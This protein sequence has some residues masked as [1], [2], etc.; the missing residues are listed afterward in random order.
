MTRRSIELGYITETIYLNG[1]DSLS[2]KSFESLTTHLR[3]FCIDMKGR[4]RKGLGIVSPSATEDDDLSF[5][6]FERFKST[7]SPWNAHSPYLEIT[8]PNPAENFAL[9]MKIRTAWIGEINTRL[10]VDI[11]TLQT[12]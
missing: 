3:D 10:A 9:Y 12:V 5:V 1:L 8:L 11:R 4:V 2:E 6:P 7:F